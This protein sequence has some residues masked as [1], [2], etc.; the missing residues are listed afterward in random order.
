MVSVIIAT[1]NRVRL[2]ERAVL[3][4]LAQIYQDFE[5]IIV[6]DASTDN[7]G[8]ILEA[9]FG[10]EIKTGRIHY[11]RNEQRQE[12]SF[13]RN[14]AMET[15][16]GKYIALLDDDD[17]W[18]PEHLKTLVDY[19]EKNEDFGCIFSNYAI[20][21]EDGSSELGVR[22]LDSY[23]GFSYR[24]M[25][26]LGVLSQ[27]ST[28]VFRREVYERVGGFKKGLNIGENR[29]FHSRIALNYPVH[30]INMTSCRQYAHQGSYSQMSSRE[31]A[32]VREEV[33]GL[34]EEN[35]IR[36]NFHLKKSL[37]ARAYMD[38][39]WFFLPDIAKAR[40]YSFRAIK[41]DKNILLKLSFLSLFLRVIFG[42]RFYFMLKQLRRG[43]K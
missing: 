34:T 8:G 18:L 6:D 38:I 26:I 17:A 13:S 4:V 27:T 23:K 2:L 21:K 43:N 40:E 25:C 41:K 11:I 39:A 20:I 19:L 1:C 30:F 37:V 16:R 3:S 28:S 22:N 5:I 14:R 29:E 24:E 10:S 33:W 9:K 15:A 12:R 42:R 7:T 31:Y 32:C 36:F 35:S